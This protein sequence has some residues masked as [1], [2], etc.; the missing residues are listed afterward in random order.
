MLLFTQTKVEDVLSEHE[1]NA[2]VSYLKKNVPK[3]FSSVRLKQSLLQELIK[4]CS[5]FEITS[6]PYPY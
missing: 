1:V 3:A 6:D 2:I 4:N 5:V